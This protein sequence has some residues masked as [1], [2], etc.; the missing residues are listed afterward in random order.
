M[1]FY[2]KCNKNGTYIVEL[3]DRDNG[4][5]VSGSYTVSNSNW[6]RHTIIFPADTTGEFDFDHS[7]SLEIS[8][9]LVAGSDTNSG[10]LGTT[11][12]AS[13]DSGSAT[14]QVN[15]TDSTSNEWMLA[16][17][18]LETDFVTPFEHI[19]YGDELARCQRY[20][21]KLSGAALT[22]YGVGN[23]DGG[24]MAQILV[25]FITEMRS[26]PGAME[27]SGTASD[28]SIRMNSNA[29]GSSV[30]TLSNRTTKNAMVIFYASGHGFTNGQACFGRAANNTNGFLA[31]SAEL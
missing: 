20:Y 12:A 4:R 23:V 22:Y 29:T 6:N 3:Y 18:Q 13:A 28:Y 26:A 17:V 24:T 11:W 19:Q 30:P 10:T 31:F 7:S 16:G 5:D 25:N 8:W 9:W 15:F 27:T 1:S 21:Q 14:G 2:I